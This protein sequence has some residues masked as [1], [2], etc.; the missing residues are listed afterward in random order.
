MNK[1]KNAEQLRALK[2]KIEQ[3]NNQAAREFTKNTNLETRDWQAEKAKLLPILDNFDRQNAELVKDKH[4]ECGAGCSACCRQLVFV[5][6]LEAYWAVK[7]ALANGIKINR[8]RLQKN[9]DEIKN[10][11][12]REQWS[13]KWEPCTFLGGSGNCLIHPARP[14]ACRAVLVSSDKI[15][16]SSAD[17]FVERYDNRDLVME[18]YGK[19]SAE[20]ANTAITPMVG[21]LQ[22]MILMVLDGKRPS[23][24]TR[25]GLYAAKSENITEDVERAGVQ[26]GTGASV[27]QE[28]S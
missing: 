3:E 13:A 18:H 20:H 17:G 28:I 9:V 1:I 23:Q 19:I 4:V 7:Y 6:Y 14:L 15:N 22:E 8:D 10:L 5:T 12:S 2:K 21:T 26:S 16:C 25:P 27:A 11:R 24:F